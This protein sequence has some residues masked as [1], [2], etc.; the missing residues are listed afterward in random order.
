MNLK[1]KLL[2]LAKKQLLENKDKKEIKPWFVYLIQCS[3]QT[4]YTGI[5]P[6]V[7]ARIDKHNSGK[8]AKYTKNRIPVVLLHAIECPNHSLAASLE[9]KIKK[10]SRS[11]KLE[12]IEQKLDFFSFED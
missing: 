10:F 6:D 2:I 7:N 1:Q 4:I 5:T 12:I 11:Q 9:Y 3:D 8:G